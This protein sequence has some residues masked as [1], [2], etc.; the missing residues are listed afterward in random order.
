MEIRLFL[1]GMLEVA[2]SIGYIALAIHLI[3]RWRIFQVED[4]HDW[5]MP[6]L[7]LVKIAAAL[8]LVWIYTDFYPDRAYADIFRYYDDSAILH[9][10]F[11]EA[12]MDYF[13]M[14]TGI[15]SGAPELSVY[16]D[17]MRNWFNTDLPFKDT[18]T[19]IR[20]CAFLRL[21]SMGT[22]FPLA[23]VLSFMAFTGLTGIFHAFRKHLPGRD[24]L[25][26]TVVFLLPSVLLWTSGIIKEAF[27]FFAT[28]WTF[29]QLHR[30][31][32]EKRFSTARVI[33]L[34]IAVVLLA[35]IKVYV[36][37]LLL[38][39]WMVWFLTASGRFR[40]KPWS[41]IVF[42]IC[43]N[44]MLGLIAPLVTG[45]SLP[46]LL[47]EKQADFYSVAATEGASSMVSGYRLDGTWPSLFSNIPVA[48][49]RSLLLPMPYQAT[50]LLMWFSVLEN[51]AYIVFVMGAVYF[52]LRRKAVGISPLLWSGL[53]FAVTLCILVGL[54]TPIIGALVRYK[55]PAI[56]FLLLF[57]SAL[58]P[59]S[60][61]V[62]DRLIKVK[63]VSEE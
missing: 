56:P 36:F 55:T 32:E 9:A 15:D 63:P 28:G 35:T 47:A 41:I 18:R 16:Y 1:N 42:Y 7:F 52:G 34:L 11:T 57:F 40:F 8:G 25:L 6:G 12:P 58:T 22:Y 60:N 17:Q 39:L 2:L 10:A 59:V 21:F 26:V 3:R 13:R 31:L 43:W 51:L 33:N 5:V 27:L 49:F 23:I 45:Y 19:I 4:F 62:I 24:A 44:S 38:P 37:F 46:V 50:N 30:L 48:L 61:T 29:Y 20:V 54:V 53:C 14:L